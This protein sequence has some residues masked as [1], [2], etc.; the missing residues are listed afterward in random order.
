MSREEVDILI[1]KHA[2]ECVQELLNTVRTNDGVS[3]FLIIDRKM[4][5]L[6]QQLQRK[7]ARK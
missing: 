6:V 2:A 5:R 4:H 3:W 7:K 1:V